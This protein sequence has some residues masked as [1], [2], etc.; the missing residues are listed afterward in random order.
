MTYTLNKPYKIRT[1]LLKYEGIGE[2]L[3]RGREDRKDDFQNGDCHLPVG[4]SAD[5]R[6]RRGLG[7]PP[8]FFTGKESHIQCDPGFVSCY[9]HCAICVC[10]HN[11]Q[12]IMLRASCKTHAGDE[13]P[14]TPGPQRDRGDNTFYPCLVNHGLSAS[15]CKVGLRFRLFG[16]FS[17]FLIRHQ[18]QVLKQRA[19]IKADQVRHLEKLDDINP[20]LPALDLGDK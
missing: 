10:V 11:H 19:G 2:E 18:P 6:H 7:A 20:P 13:P 9:C 1:G 15:L 14:P 16:R 8:I 4:G 17:G 12:P 3:A 5:L